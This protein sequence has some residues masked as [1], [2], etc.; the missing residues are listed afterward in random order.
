MNLA[1][2]RYADNPIIDELVVWPPRSC[3][4]ESIRACCVLFRKP[5][6]E[7][8][9]TDGEMIIRHFERQSFAGYWAEACVIL[10]LVTSIKLVSDFSFEAVSDREKLERE[11][12]ANREE[13]IEESEQ[14]YAEGMYQQFLM[15]YGE[16]CKNLPPQSLQ[17]LTHA[18]QQLGLTG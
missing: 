16:D 5:F 2:E 17:K 7:L 11:V 8:Q 12:L 6:I 18:R 9:M 4:I 3:R 1:L 15:Q 14:M 10:E 13:C